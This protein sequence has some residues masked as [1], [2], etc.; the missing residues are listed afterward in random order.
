MEDLKVI[1]PHRFLPTEIHPK[2]W[3]APGSQV[4]GDVKIGTD[5]SV[6]FNSVIRGDVN[7]IRIGER[8]NVQ[9]NSVIH[10]SHEGNPAILG[11]DVTIGHAC[12][13]HACKIGDQAL[14]GM[15]SLILDEAE[16]GEWVLLGAGSLVTQRTKIPPHTLAMGRPAKVIRDLKEAEI[17]ELR[18]SAAH[19]VRL[20]RTYRD[21]KSSS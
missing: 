10:V 3:R 11:N 7:Y 9:D 17:E 20:M 14:I 8:T 18:F 19:Y 1:Y 6:W 13:I 4:I 2:A 16:I 15:G 5:S 21:A 12:V